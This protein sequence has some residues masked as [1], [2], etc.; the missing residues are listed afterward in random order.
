MKKQIIVGIVLLIVFLAFSA[1]DDTMKGSDILTSFERTVSPFEKI[2]ID[3][4]SEVCF[5]VSHEYRVVVTIN[6]NLTE[7]VK[8]VSKNNVLDIGMKGG[9]YSDVKYSIDVY[10][11]VLTGVKIYGFGKFYCNDKIITNLFK[12]NLSGSGE[13]NANIEC[14]NFSADLSGFGNIIVSGNS[15]ESN[16]NISGSGDFYGKEFH[17]KN[18][19]IYFNGFGNANI[20]ATDSL[21]VNMSGSGVVNYYGNPTEV[22]S[23][24]SGFGK[25]NKK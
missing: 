18:T 5:Y 11:P 25:I 7:Y 2:N 16:I 1:C 17:T 23:N 4:V 24:I 9:S 20:H 12:T 10:S 22:N 19:T 14:D 21:R 13:I 15:I 8:I 6:S 3:D